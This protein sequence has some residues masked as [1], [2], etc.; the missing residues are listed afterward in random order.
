MHFIGRSLFALHFDIAYSSLTIY[1]IS[2]Y[3]HEHQLLQVSDLWGKVQKTFLFSALLIPRQTKNSFI[4]IS[5]LPLYYWIRIDSSI[6][7]DT[8]QL[9]GIDY[10]LLGIPPSRMS[11]SRQK[12]V[13]FAPNGT[14]PGIFQIRFSIYKMY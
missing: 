4:N 6:L 9:A 2:M 5:L 13:R 14:N 11:D 10:V 7:S 12:W 1:V 8:I 3:L